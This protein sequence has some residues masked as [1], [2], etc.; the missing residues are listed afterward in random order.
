MSRPLTESSEG[1]EAGIVR[2]AEGRQTHSYRGVGDWD[3]VG[4]EMT[5][6]LLPMTEPNETRGVH[7]GYSTPQEP[8]GPVFP[9]RPPYL[10]LPHG[11]SVLGA[12]TEKPLPTIVVHP[13]S[14]EQ[15]KRRNRGRK[16]D[17]I[18]RYEPRPPFSF[19]L[20]GKPRRREG[21]VVTRVR[22][23]TKHLSFLL[24]F[25]PTYLPFSLSP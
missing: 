17:K 12:D 19:V 20:D 5:V 23:P 6:A 4:Q 22:T 25:L 18:Q 16:R 11:L 2:R 7:G 15:D 14:K 24:S 21:G 9:T 3:W 13:Q 1:L 10:P 8:L